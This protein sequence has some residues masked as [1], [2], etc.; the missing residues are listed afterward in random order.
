M[1]VA[2]KN[3][4]VFVSDVVYLKIDFSLRDLNYSLSIRLHLLFAFLVLVERVVALAEC[5]FHLVHEMLMIE[6]EHV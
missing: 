4:H 5:L 6:F 1:L 2:K 3:Q